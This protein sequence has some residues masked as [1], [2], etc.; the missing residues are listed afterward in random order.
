MWSGECSPRAAAGVVKL[1]KCTFS[2]KPLQLLP[3]LRGSESVNRSAIDPKSAHSDSALNPPAW[4]D[5]MPLLGSVGGRGTGSVTSRRVSRDLSR[6][7]QY[8]CGLP[9]SGRR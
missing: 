4:F 3:N 2:V 9:G 1:V 7:A 5:A 8:N 6:P